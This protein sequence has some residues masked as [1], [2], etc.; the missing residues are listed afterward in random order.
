A[1]L[2]EQLDATLVMIQ[3]E[4]RGRI[5]MVTIFDPALPLIECNVGEINQVFMNIILN[6]IQAME[7][8]GVLTVATYW[9]AQAKEARVEIT[10]TGQG[11]PAG[12]R[13]HIFDPFFTTKEVGKGTGLGLAI[14]A[15]IVE[16]HHGQI[17]VQSE[18]GHGARF[19]VTLPETQAN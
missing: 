6:G 16:K 2:N 3:S 13:Y 9:N 1:N 8:K 15:S 7:E 5:E 10:D 4:I 12:L 14:S 17:E 11:I 19:I 18:E